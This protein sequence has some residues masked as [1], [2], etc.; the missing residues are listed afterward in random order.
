MSA[1][2]TGSAISRYPLSPLQ[3]GMLFHHVHSGRE[4]GVDIE[5]LEA[6]LRE[7]IDEGVFARAWALVAGQHAV[8]RTRFEWEGLEAPFQEVVASIAVPLEVNDLSSHPAAEQERTIADFLGA[9]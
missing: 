4:T 6:R 3:H 9:D 1:T 8:L 2:A 7:S 5:Q